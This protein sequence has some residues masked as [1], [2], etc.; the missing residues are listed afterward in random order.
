MPDLNFD[1]IF[2]K[3]RYPLLILLGGLILIG[4]G[5]LYFKSGVGLPQTKVE[6]LPARNASQSDAGGDDI[7]VE[8]AGEVM[9]PGVYQLASNARINDLLIKSGGFSGGADRDWVSK[10]LNRA[11]RL[12]DGQK[13]YIPK[14]GELA[15][16]QDYQSSVRGANNEGGYQTTSASFSSDSSGKININSASLTQLD[17]LPGIAQKRGQKIIDHRPYSKIEEL[18]SK[19]VLT[20]SVYNEIKDLITVY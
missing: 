20:Q 6:V 14:T 13:V 10:Y 11:A 12:S 4:A 17:S 5:I 2:F 19:G 7:T 16:H 9:T 18:L 15:P 3:F 8:I 1:E